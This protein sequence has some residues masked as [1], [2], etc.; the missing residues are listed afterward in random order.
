[1][2]VM[3]GRWR[4]NSRPFNSVG[5]LSDQYHVRLRSK[6]CAQPLAKLG[7]L[8]RSKFESG[9]EH[10]LLTPGPEIVIGPVYDRR[11]VCGD[12]N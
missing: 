12:N 5:H 6:Y 7:G 10:A 1:M 2:R 11:L 3:S 4:R 8:R 9:S